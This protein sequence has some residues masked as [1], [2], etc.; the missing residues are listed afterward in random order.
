MHRCFSIRI[1]ADPEYRDGMAQRLSRVA[2]PTAKPGHA[3]APATSTHNSH[4][5]ATPWAMPPAA[6]VRTFMTPDRTRLIEHLAFESPLSL[7]AMCEVLRECLGLPPFQ[8]GSENET[9]W[10]SATLDGVVYNLSRPYGAGT[11]QEWDDTVP[12]GCNFGLSLLVLNESPAAHDA[13]W[14][15]TELVPRVARSLAARL[16]K[17]VYHHRTWLGVGQNERRSIAFEPDLFA[18]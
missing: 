18:G 3:A 11:L 12:P 1:H 10:G 15:S 9:E 2:C 17:V 6:I 16:R 14:S 8:L 4:G 13:T 7:E 5:L